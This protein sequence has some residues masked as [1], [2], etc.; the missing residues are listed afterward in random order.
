MAGGAGKINEFNK[1]LTQEQRTNNARKAGIASAKKKK[2]MKTIREFALAINSAQPTEEIKTQLASMGID[3]E[4]A[5]NAAAIAAAVF[6]S[7]WSGD[8][9]A[10]DK[11]ERYVG[12]S[13]EA[14]STEGQGQLADLISGLQDKG[15][16]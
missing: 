10:V 9:K 13:V 2:E 4:E 15:G 11:W 3:P 1:T 5:T 7:A 6:M 16:E 8:M 14:N 12:Q